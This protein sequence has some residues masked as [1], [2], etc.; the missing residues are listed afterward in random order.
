MDF[1][2]LIDI[3]GRGPDK[4]TNPNPCGARNFDWNSGNDS[5][6]GVVSSDNRVYFVGIGIL[7]DNLT[8]PNEDVFADAK[9]IS[10]GHPEFQRYVET[11]VYCN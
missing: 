7:P 3:M 2:D 10:P 11:T 6:Y 9:D 5:L 1:G 8:D 4:T